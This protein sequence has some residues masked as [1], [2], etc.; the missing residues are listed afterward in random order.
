MENYI[1]LSFLNDFVFC[2]RSIYYHQLY[3]RYNDQ[4]YKQTP[5][6][7]GATAHQSIDDAT[8]STSKNILQ[9]IEIYSEKY[10][11]VGKI[12]VFD[13]Q[14][15]KLIERKRNIKT[16]Y[17]GYIFQVYAQYFG[18]EEMGYVVNNIVIHDLIHNKNYDIPLP[19]NDSIMLQ[20]FEDIINKI[21]HY[22]L[23]DMDFVPNIEKCKQCIYSPLCDKSLC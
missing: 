22:N 4:Y 19:Q 15:G 1:T 10:N 6:I 2:P 12:D 18:L 7:L 20:K 11:I 13:T 21:Q 14:K 9:G 3:A 8:Y 5:Q 17:D 23:S 16:I